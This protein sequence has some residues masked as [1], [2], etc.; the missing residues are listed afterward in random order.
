MPNTTDSAVTRFANRLRPDDHL[1]IEGGPLAVGP[2]A[3]C[4]R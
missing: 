3:G 2:A 1:H 4:N